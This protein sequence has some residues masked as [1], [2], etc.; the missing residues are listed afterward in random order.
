MGSDAPS[1][2]SNRDADGSISAADV[3]SKGPL[4][5]G[6]G[7][8]T[9][10]LRAFNLFAAKIRPAVRRDNPHL[11][12]CETERAIGMRWN[13]LAAS[14]RQEYLNAARAGV[15]AL[16]ANPAAA[17]P[18][19]AQGGELLD[20]HARQTRRRRKRA[21]IEAEI[22]AENLLKQQQIAARYG[23]G[24]GL[25]MGLGASRAHSNPWGGHG[26]N[27][28]ADASAMFPRVRGHGR[29]LERS[30]SGTSSSTAD[31]GE[32]APSVSFGGLLTG[33]EGGEGQS[34]GTVRLGQSVRGMVDG[35]FEAGF[36]VSLRVEG[37]SAVLRGVVFTPAPAVPV[38][39]LNDVA[40][41]VPHV[42]GATA[43]EG[44]REQG[45]QLGPVE[46]AAEAPTQQEGMAAAV[47]S[48]AA[49]SEA[50]AAAAAVAE[51]EAA[52]AEKAEA[53]AGAVTEATAAEDAAAAAAAAALAGQAMAVSGEAAMPESG[54]A[55]APMHMVHGM[56]SEVDAMH[57]EVVQHTVDVAAD[58]HGY[59]VASAMHVT[60]NDTAAADLNH[61]VAAGHSM[62][63]MH[64][65]G[66]SVEGSVPSQDMVG[67]ISA[68]QDMWH[69]SHH[70][71]A[72][73]LARVTAE[74]V[75]TSSG[76]VHGGAFHVVDHTNPSAAAAHFTFASQ[77]LEDLLTASQ[78]SAS[79][80][81]MNLQPGT[82]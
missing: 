23:I 74:G 22:E 29:D 25:G 12:V 50:L 11:S 3:E 30:G 79:Q 63:P 9:L 54:T 35:V 76:V 58:T 48:E 70:H 38:T 56:G 34:G 28:A 42:G 27:S 31:E 37:C 73:A 8:V 21:E 20:A 4:P 6:S 1:D 65:A 53:A 61:A 26:G 47:T 5:P 39:S 7:Q 82:F 67:T 59:V 81:P 36:F 44:E 71:H 46:G 72:Q 33:G 60:G 17:A 57:H 49:A 66:A 15:P 13:A 62:H 69:A 10:N 43:A 55:I 32:F 78:D 2:A 77:H 52:A 45:S 24:A 40:A 68:A 18:A 75:P 41:G 80:V 14:A 64:D 16:G 19:A 51:A